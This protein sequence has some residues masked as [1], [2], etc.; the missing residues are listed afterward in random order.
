MGCGINAK[1]LKSEPEDG[2]IDLNF[3][4]FARCLIRTLGSRD[5]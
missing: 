4:P 2:L 3:P 5:P 1:W